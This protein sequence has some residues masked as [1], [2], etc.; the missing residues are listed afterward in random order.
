MIC[1]IFFLL[2]VVEVPCGCIG[3]PTIVGWEDTPQVES[4]LPVGLGPIS[5]GHMPYTRIFVSNSK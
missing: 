1:C 4:L 5:D 2:D 3:T